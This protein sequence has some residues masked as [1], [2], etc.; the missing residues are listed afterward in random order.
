MADSSP[1]RISKDT[2]YQRIDVA[3][4]KD[5]KGV[6]ETVVRTAP[7]PIVITDLSGR[8]MIWNEAAELT[9]GW[10]KEEV[11]GERPPQVTAEN[12]EEF[13]FLVARAASGETIRGIKTQRTARNGKTIHLDLNLSPVRG[14]DGQIIGTAAVMADITPQ[15]T[16]EQALWRSE[17]RFKAF[18]DNFPG[19]A[20]MKDLE[21]RYVYANRATMQW[22][23]HNDCIGKSDFELM[24]REFASTRHANDKLALEN[25][26]LPP[27]LENRFSGDSW[28]YLIVHRFAIKS[29]VG[30]PVLIGG[31]GLDITEQRQTESELKKASQHLQLLSRRLIDAREEEK[32]YLARELHDEIGQSLTALKFEIDAARRIGKPEV[33]AGRLEQS[34]AMVDRL[35]KTVRNLSL[36]LHPPLLDEMG[37]VAAIRENVLPQAARVGLKVR[38]VA[39]GLD[40][41]LESALEITTFRV[42]QEAVTNIIRHAE[43]ARVDLE[44]R[45]E[46]NRLA[47]L[48]R[49]DGVG[50][51]VASTLEHMAQFGMMSMRE[52]V[53]LSGGSF[54]C[55]SGFG[56]G[57]E[58]RFIF[59]IGG[60][61]S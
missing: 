1:K 9:F 31:I 44:V 18:M 36:A 55:K 3:V 21:G 19:N 58:L 10:S 42:I 43:A 4:S 15:K 45:I 37:L 13:H 39:D 49:D 57:T 35:M 54:S 40:E 26:S 32:R 22:P 28:R 33:V 34:M 11:V 14:E 12:L 27:V 29:P 6:Y 59:P 38:F 24:P 56:E 25:G 8:V 41:R 23:N 20:W 53:E 51:D 7:V 5:Q 52:R 30:V 16:M 46:G 50:F 47:V 48:V 2:A 60:T 17:Q 61:G